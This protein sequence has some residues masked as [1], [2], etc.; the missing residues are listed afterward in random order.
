MDPPDQVVVGGVAVGGLDRQLGL[1]DPPSPCT[2]LA[3]TTAPIGVV[4][5]CWRR[6]ASRSPAVAGRRTGATVPHRAKPPET[7]R[8]PLVQGRWHAA[9]W[10]LHGW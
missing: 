9:R 3:W 10:P 5:S 7:G 1:A 8:R 4:V 2:A 6:A